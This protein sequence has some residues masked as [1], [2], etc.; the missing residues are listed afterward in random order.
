MAKRDW[1][2]IPKAPDTHGN[3]RCS[4]CKE[5]KSPEQFSKN[6]HQTSGLNYACKSCMKTYTRKYNLPTKYGISASQ[7]AEMLLKQG[8]KCA[9][10]GKVFDM[11]GKSKDRAC[12]DHNHTT[13]EVRDLLCGGCNLAAGNVGDS[14]EKAKQLEIYLK[15]WNC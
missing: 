3:Y 7:F 5:W 15:K 10:C 1:G 2:R 11:E 4:M 14:S 12:V 6:R 9:C 8:G 13:N